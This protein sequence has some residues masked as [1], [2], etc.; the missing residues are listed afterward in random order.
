MLLLCAAG[1]GRSMQFL[2]LGQL[3]HGALCTSIL[4]LNQLSRHFKTMLSSLLPVAV[5]QYPQETATSGACGLTL[6][7]CCAS[8]CTR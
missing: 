5:P 2:G 6:S 1:G 7:V 8:G 3:D 4:S